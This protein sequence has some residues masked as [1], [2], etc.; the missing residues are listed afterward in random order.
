MP[1]GQEIEARE[2]RI[3]LRPSVPSSSSTLPS[4][5]APVERTII[6]SSAYTTLHSATTTTAAIVVHRGPVAVAAAAAPFLLLPAFLL[7]LPPLPAADFRG[8]GDARGVD[9]DALPDMAAN[10][11]RATRTC[12][13][14]LLAKV[15]KNV[16]RGSVSAAKE[17]ENANVA[18]SARTFFFRFARSLGRPFA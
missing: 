6:V 18:R 7:L 17:N 1:W 5:S 3:Q 4:A 14:R 11:A 8:A 12:G 9:D 15:V 13:G 2:V 16:E 10:M